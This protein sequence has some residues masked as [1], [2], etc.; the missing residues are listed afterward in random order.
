MKDSLVICW[1]MNCFKAEFTPSALLPG[2]TDSESE[3]NPLE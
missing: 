2:E 3:E 1:D